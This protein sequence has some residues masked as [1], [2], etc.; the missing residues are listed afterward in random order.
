MNSIEL[1][2]STPGATPRLSDRRPLLWAFVTA[3]TAAAALGVVVP[4]LVAHGNV[5]ASVIPLAAAVPATRESTVPAASGVFVGPGSGA[6]AS[7][8]A[9]TF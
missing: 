1:P 2:Q 4:R 8:P 7:A 5:Q 9:P 6:D 3:L